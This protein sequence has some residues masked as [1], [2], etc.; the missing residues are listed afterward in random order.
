MVILEI[1]F[2]RSPGENWRRGQRGFKEVKEDGGFLES[3]SLGQR[4]VYGG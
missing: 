3:R 4:Y 2:D 1:E